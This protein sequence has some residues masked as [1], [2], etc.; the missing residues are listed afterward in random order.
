MGQLNASG[1]ES[2]GQT[3]SGHPI[4]E[5]GQRPEENHVSRTS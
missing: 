1:Y 5:N 4:I 2:R 3:F